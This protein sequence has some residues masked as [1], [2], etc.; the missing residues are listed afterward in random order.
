MTF[1]AAVE[2]LFFLLLDWSSFLCFFSKCPFPFLK[3]LIGF[4]VHFV[5]MSFRFSLLEVS[6]L[7]VLL[8]F[9]GPFSEIV[10]EARRRRD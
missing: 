1:F 6:I 5:E 7:I 4:P 10:V 9:L 8:T 3:G 2:I